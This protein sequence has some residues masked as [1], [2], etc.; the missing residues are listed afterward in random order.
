MKIL[1]N[2]PFVDLVLDEEERLIEQA[3]NND[4]YRDDSKLE[5]TKKLLADAASRYQKLHTAKSITIRINQLD[6]IRIKAKAKTKQIPYQTLLGILIHQY[7]EGEKS[8]Q[9]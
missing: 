1:K 5:K 6:L 7:A 9:L 2:N 4:L 3:L 8:L